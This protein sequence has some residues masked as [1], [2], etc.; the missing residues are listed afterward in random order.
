M[1]KKKI[2]VIVIVVFALAL[3]VGG[4][5]LWKRDKDKDMDEGEG[6]EDP[7][8]GG[9]SGT[10]PSGGGSTSL[11]ANIA[12]VKANLG[13]GKLYKGP[14]I[15]IKWNGDRYEAIFYAANDRVIIFDAGKVIRRGKFS[16]GGKTLIM[17][18]GVT[19]TSGSVWANLADAI[20]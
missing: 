3:G 13:S 12:A 7:G 15:G 10:K 16:N 8:T 19:A 17:D 2:V 18:N 11:P 5:I 1:D 4:F 14:A 9:G 20:K 6:V